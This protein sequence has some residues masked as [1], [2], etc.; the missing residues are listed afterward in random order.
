MPTVPE[1]ERARPGADSLGGKAARRR[2]EE[3]GD[4]CRCGVDASERL[5]IA[6]GVRHDCTLPLIRSA[7]ADCSPPV[8]TKGMRSG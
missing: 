7:W 1:E 8:T 4:G 6:S 3:A 2:E 5:I